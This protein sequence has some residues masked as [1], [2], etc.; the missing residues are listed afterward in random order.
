MGNTPPED[1]KDQEILRD[2]H[3]TELYQ[4]FSRVPLLTCIWMS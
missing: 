4:G 2:L 1:Q 3:Q